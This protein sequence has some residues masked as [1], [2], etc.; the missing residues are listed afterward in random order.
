MNLLQIK[1]NSLTVQKTQNKE[2]RSKVKGICLEYELHN[3][4]HFKAMIL[5]SPE[6]IFNVCSLQEE[7]KDRLNFYC[8]WWTQQMAL[9]IWH[10]QDVLN[11]LS[12]PIIQGH[13]NSCVC[14]SVCVRTHT[15]IH[16]TH[17]L[18]EIC[19]VFQE[20]K[21]L[22]IQYSISHAILST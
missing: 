14:V 5:K 13:L 9:L 17:T 16:V 7:M 10:P 4:S 3:S 6:W 22:H 20:K 21:N 18:S 2:P 1:G 12:E 11:K 15:Y 19:M 8:I